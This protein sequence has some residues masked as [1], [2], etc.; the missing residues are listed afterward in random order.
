[1]YVDEVRLIV[2]MVVLLVG[3]G[4]AMTTS[5]IIKRRHDLEA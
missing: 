3:I 1:M 2:M 4:M 5:M